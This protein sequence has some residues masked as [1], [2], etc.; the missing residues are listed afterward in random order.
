MSVWK[1]N[2]WLMFHTISKN[3]DEKYK[4]KYEDFF[5]SFKS[6]I[7]C[8]ICRTHYIQNISKPGLLISENIN[9]E[10]IFN[11]TIDLHNTVNRMHR[12]TLWDYNKAVNI[13]NSNISFPTIK[14]FIY[15]YVLFNLKKNQEKTEGLIKM[16]KSL[17]YVYPN[18]VI[19]DRLIDFTEKF[20]LNTDTIKKWLY[21][22]LLII[23]NT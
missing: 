15:E 1:Q 19:R 20:E 11:W 5:N 13:Y 8:K 10:R 9:S 17:S 14:M 7:P 23:K 2:T 4:D 3:Y 21:A 22:Y 12:K 6:V 18:K 16:L